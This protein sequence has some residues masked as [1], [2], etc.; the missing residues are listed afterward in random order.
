[1][2][3]ISRIVEHDTSTRNLFMVQSMNDYAGAPLLLIQEGAAASES[4]WL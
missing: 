4:E 2:R 1:M 3:N